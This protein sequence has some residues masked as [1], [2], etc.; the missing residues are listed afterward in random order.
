[1]DTYRVFFGDYEVTDLVE[2]MTVEDSLSELAVRVTLE[3]AYPVELPTPALSGPA[4]IS[5]IPPGASTPV[6]LI[7]STAHSAVIWEATRS[8][9]QTAS[10][11]LTV[12]VYDRLIYLMK[13]EEEY[14]HQAGTAT[15]RLRRYAQDWNLP[16]ATL[17]DT[18]QKLKLIVYREKSLAEMIKAD[19]RETAQKNG[20][21]Y[22]V[23]MTPSGISLFQIGA[24]SPTWTLD[25]LVESGEEVNRTLEGTVTKVK[26]LG[27]GK[28]NA[29]SPLLATLT[30]HAD[31]YGTLQ[32]T[33]R[34]GKNDALATVKSE[35]NALL[36]GPDETLTL[37]CAKS[38][39]TLRSGDEVSY[40]GTDWIVCK[41]RHE[42]KPADSMNVT[43]GGLAYVRRTYFR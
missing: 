43:L 5:G 14:L 39:P 20:K 34:K 12:I 30:E 36:G 15:A 37:P 42:W 29:R 23:R 9:V 25:G 31:K 28:D 3:M 33:I 35:A 16:L 27:Q 13:S 10:R 24:G 4:R 17:A 26:I 18:A 38:I 21:L 19:L 41:V 22:A 1:M 8:R 11:F 32:K 2:S 7:G 6:Y 40:G